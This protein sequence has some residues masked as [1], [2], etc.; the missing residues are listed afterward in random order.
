VGHE[1]DGCGRRHLLGAVRLAAPR[2]NDYSV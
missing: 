2:P 1:H